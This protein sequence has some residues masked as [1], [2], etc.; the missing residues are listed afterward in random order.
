MQVVLA[1]DDS[2]GALICYDVSDKKTFGR[3]SHWCQVSKQ[4]LPLLSVLSLSAWHF[5]CVTA[6]IVPC[7]DSIAFFRPAHIRTI[8]FHSRSFEQCWE[9]KCP[10]YSSAPNTT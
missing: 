1:I 9:M 6:R 2:D 8:C 3:A 4:D 7:S 5:L 10:Y